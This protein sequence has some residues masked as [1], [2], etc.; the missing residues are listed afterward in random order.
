MQERKRYYKRESFFLI[1][2][3]SISICIFLLTVVKYLFS[4]PLINKLK[5]E[6][7]G[8]FWIISSVIIL[9]FIILK[10]CSYIE[11]VDGKIITGNIFLF[12]N[13]FLSFLRLSIAIKIEEI[14]EIKIVDASFFKLF[15]FPSL[16]G[17]FYTSKACCIFN[18]NFYYEFNPNEIK[19]IDS[20]IK[21]I[22]E[23]KSKKCNVSN[24]MSLSLEEWNKKDKFCDISI[25][26]VYLIFIFIILFSF[27]LLLK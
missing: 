11:I 2:L 23:L 24:E 6:E 17:P 7:I 22:L 12:V 15:F 4:F 27:I 25:A 21:D 20:F 9:M 1:I 8:D 5:Q 14:E 3:G 19:K 10:R 13:R 16:R 18:N 26:F